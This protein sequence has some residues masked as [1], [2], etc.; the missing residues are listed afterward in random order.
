LLRKDGTWM[1]NITAFTLPEKEQE[2]QLGAW[3]LVRALDTRLAW[4]GL[5]LGVS[6]AQAMFDSV[7]TLSFTVFTF[8]PSL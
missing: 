3:A 6:G 2:Q 7:I 4:K 5:A 8:D 1:L